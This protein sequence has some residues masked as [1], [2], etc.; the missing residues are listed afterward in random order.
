VTVIKYL[1]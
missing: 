1:H